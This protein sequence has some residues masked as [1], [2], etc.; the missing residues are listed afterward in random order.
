LRGE[1]SSLWH[2]VS[3]SFLLSVLILHHSIKTFNLLVQFPE[4]IIVATSSA[5]K[6][7]SVST[8]LKI[9]IDFFLPNLDIL[10][11]FS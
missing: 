9:P 5:S 3:L 1:L 10:L 2:D 8:V 6:D 4:T 7:T 11:K